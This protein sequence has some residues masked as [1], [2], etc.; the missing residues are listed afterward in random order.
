MPDMEIKNEVAR[1][2]VDE[3]KIEDHFGCSVAIDGDYAI[4][5]AHGE[6]VVGESSG[7]VYMFERKAG[8][9]WGAVQKPRPSDLKAGDLFGFSVA[10]SGSLAIVGAPGGEMDDPRR[11]AAYV[12]ERG[13]DGQ[14]VEIRK[15]EANDERERDNF[16]R[17]V[18]ISGA[19]AIVGVFFGD[20]EEPDAGAAYVFERDVDG[21]WKEERKLT[22]EDAQERRFFGYSVALSGDRA[23]I[24]AKW[25]DAA[26]ESSGAAYIFER[27]EEG[28][29][30]EVLKL[31]ESDSAGVYYFGKSVSISGGRVILGA[32]T[33]GYGA[34]GAT[35]AAHVFER[36]GAGVWEEAQKLLAGDGR[37][38]DDF[39]HSVAISGDLA[40]V[41]SYGKDTNA[42]NDGAAYVFERGARGQWVE[43]TKLLA[44]NGQENDFLGQS[45]AISG[46][47]AVVGAGLDAN[48]SNIGAAYVFECGKGGKRHSAA[49]IK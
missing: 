19:R 2:L 27:D 16:G 33:R 11:G 46:D 21:A 35:G 47:L 28:A 8:G 38:Y 7:A 5:G 24:G 43:I 49:F 48:I 31:Q 1:L 23:I 32:N 40:I 10:V 25:E 17:S 4:V 6:D 22:V 12:F 45:V 44:I 18:D 42:S 30:E 39:G 15:F 29:W 20:A 36:D 14:W 9:A 3:I 13:A 37:E 34:E 41:G 26:C